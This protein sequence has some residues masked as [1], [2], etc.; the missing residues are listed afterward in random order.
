MVTKSVRYRD[1]LAVLSSSDW[2][3]GKTP[4]GASA[5]SVGEY[6]RPFLFGK[7]SMNLLIPYKPI[8]NH[9]DP[10][11][12]EFTYGDCKWRARKLKS[13]Q[14]GDVLFFHTTIAG[15]KY[16]TAYYVVERVLDT[17]EAVKDKYISSKYCNPHI[18]EYT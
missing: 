5:R 11:L 10:L 4:V 13:L 17:G 6:G 14:K 2:L 1:G 12:D 8:Y 18:G 16:I 3:L 7:S 9:D 15:K